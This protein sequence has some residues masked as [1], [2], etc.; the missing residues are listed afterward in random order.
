MPLYRRL[1]SYTLLFG[2]ALRDE[3]VRWF[4]AGDPM[5]YLSTSLLTLPLFQRGNKQAAREAETCPHQTMTGNVPAK[6][7]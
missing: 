3:T 5:V 2:R 1:T 4:V 7:I 6:E